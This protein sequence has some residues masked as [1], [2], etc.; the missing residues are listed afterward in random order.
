MLNYETGHVFIIGQNNLMLSSKCCGRQAQF[1]TEELLFLTCPLLSLLFSN[2]SSSWKLNFWN[3]CTLL[4]ISSSARSISSTVTKGKE[5]K[6][7][8]PTDFAGFSRFTKLRK[9][10]RYRNSHEAMSE[11]RPKGKQ[12]Q[13]STARRACRLLS[14]LDPLLGK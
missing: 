9:F 1:P 13:I 3:F 11:T 12:T 6:G 14:L 7:T 8:D 2:S 4:R 10:S 5:L